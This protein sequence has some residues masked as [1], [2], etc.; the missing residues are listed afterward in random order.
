MNN[1]LEQSDFGRELV[2]R[3]LNQGLVNAMRAMLRAR[4]GEIDDLDSLAGRLAGD[5]LD[6]NVARIVAGATLDELR[7]TS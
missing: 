6:G 3:G 2:E 7:R 1:I 4:F 5:D